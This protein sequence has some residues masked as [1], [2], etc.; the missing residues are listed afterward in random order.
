MFNFFSLWSGAGEPLSFT[1][2]QQNTKQPYRKPIL[3]G[4]TW[5]RHPGTHACQRRAFAGMVAN[6]G[7]K[8]VTGPESSQF[9]ARLLDLLAAMSDRYFP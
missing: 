6:S 5:I 8:A 7:E 4:T 2:V 3:L 1:S 9:V